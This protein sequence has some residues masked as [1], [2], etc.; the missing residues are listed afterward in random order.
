MVRAISAF[1]DFCYLVRRDT[2][3]TDTL[4]D[5]DRALERF[6]RER[7]I[8]RSTGVRKGANAFS[9]P[10]QHSLSHYHYLIEEFAAPNGLC[11]SITESKH[12]KAVKQPWRRSSRFE[13]LGQMLIT[14]QRLDK[15]AAA[16]VDYA[17]RGLLVGPCTNLPAFVLEENA[18]S[19]RKDAA[20]DAEECIEDFHGSVEDVGT[21][22]GQPTD[23]D[24]ESDVILARTPGKLIQNNRAFSYTNVCM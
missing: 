5:I 6:H 24:V 3:N 19:A 16:R 7:E 17:A 11:S 20:A 15:L 2:I 22:D 21:G 14:N 10:R 18:E 13:A 9:L 1:L 4:D 23:D 8:F 12:I